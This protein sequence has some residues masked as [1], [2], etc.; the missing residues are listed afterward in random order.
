M[1][2]P[3]NK[4]IT[5]LGATLTVYSIGYFAHIVNRSSDSVRRWERTKVLPTPIFSLPEDKRRWYTAAELYGYAEI[6]RKSN[7]R[8]RV[9]IEDTP[10][11]RMCNDFKLKLK[12][13]MDRDIAQFPKEL[14]REK[15]TNK[16]LL[17][18]SQARW[19]AHAQTIIDSNVSN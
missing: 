15:E 6:F 10:F 18:K 11:K 16:A 19:K 13:E 5:Y 2:T 14:L 8:P 4:R 17:E 1:S 3:R 9:K 7:I 12:Y